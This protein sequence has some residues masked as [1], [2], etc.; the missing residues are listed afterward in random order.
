MRN[1][2]LF[3]KVMK[4]DSKVIALIRFLP[5][6]SSKI[7]AKKAGVSQTTVTKFFKGEQLRYDKMKAVFIATWAVYKDYKAKE[8]ALMELFMAEE[9]EIAKLRE[10]YKEELK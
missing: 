9:K 1:N 8:A 5:H 6:G 2:K 4:V 7:I 10:K 3:I